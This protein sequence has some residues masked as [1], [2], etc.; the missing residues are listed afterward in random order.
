[1]SE[2]RSVRTGVV[3]H[4]RAD[5]IWIAHYV[6]VVACE[7]GDGLGRGVGSESEGDTFRAWL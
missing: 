6:R 7:L 4:L 5:V 1:M 3:V 2:L